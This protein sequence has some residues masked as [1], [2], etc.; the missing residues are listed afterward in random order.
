M[1]AKTHVRQ[2]LGSPC[3]VILQVFHI[4][5]DFHC[6]VAVV[7]KLR[8]FLSVFP[9]G[10]G[11]DVATG[12]LERGKNIPHAGDLDWPRATTDRAPVDQVP[13]RFSCVPRSQLCE[14]RMLSSRRHRC[15]C[16]WS[17]V[18]MASF[19][20]GASCSCS[21]TRSNRFSEEVITNGELVPA[22]ATRSRNA[23]YRRCW[24][25]GIQ[26]RRMTVCSGS[27][28]CACTNICSSVPKP[29]YGKRSRRKFHVQVQG[30]RAAFVCLGDCV[31]NIRCALVC[32]PQVSL[33]STLALLCFVPQTL[34]SSQHYVHQL[35]WQPKTAWPISSERQPP[36]NQDM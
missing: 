29:L 19:A 27:K 11:I 18:V 20:W 21:A 5:S 15:T 24:V 22:E 17:M 16:S 34:F 2:A 6:T 12:A 33:P 4:W 30:L 10:E 25:F 9:A 3:P 1:L 23:V 28:S 31:S 7:K 32:P 26:I 13:A 14:G 35:Q 8:A 36:A